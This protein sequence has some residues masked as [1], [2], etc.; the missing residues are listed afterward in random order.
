MGPNLQKYLKKTGMEMENEHESA[1]EHH[2]ELEYSEDHGSVAEGKAKDPL[3]GG[4]RGKQLAPW[5]KK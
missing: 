1:D 3:H 5:M 4:K 2:A